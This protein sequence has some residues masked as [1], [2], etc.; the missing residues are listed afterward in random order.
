[1]MQA[2][3]SAAV[4]LLAASIAGPAFAQAPGADTYKAKCAMC[5]G[6]DGL[7]VT[8]MGKNMKIL[9]FKAPEM[10]K[11]SDAQF[12]ASTKN[13]K[14]KMPAYNGKLTDAQIKDVVAYIRT[15]QK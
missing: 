13:G 4:I 11:A 10:V 12:I 5:H 2:I 14:N 7:A 6:A 1:M 15:L 3:R 8:P 9:S